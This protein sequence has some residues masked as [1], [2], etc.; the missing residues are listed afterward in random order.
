MTEQWR[1]AVYDGIVYEEL[2]KVSNLGRILSLN[3][4]HTG[5]SGLMT[6]VENTGG[7]LQV[8]LS[9]NGKYIKTIWGM[10]YK[11]ENE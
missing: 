11:M 9:K 8:K 2:Y 10:G 5:K 7:Y 1:T 6:P 4:N 3:Y